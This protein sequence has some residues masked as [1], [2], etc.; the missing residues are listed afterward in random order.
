[1]LSEITSHA[2]PILVHFPIA[3]I[4]ISLLYELFLV[5]KKKHLA[6]T[7][8]LWLWILCAI[9]AALSVATGPDELA[10][11]NTTYI[12]THSRLADITMLLTFF[13]VAY[14]LWKWYK[15]S[16]IRRAQLV[17]YMLVTIATCVCV[18]TTGYY[19]GKMV[20]DQGIG[21]KKNGAYVTPPKNIHFHRQNG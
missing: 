19:G 3:L 10:R 21:V 7:D 14:K 17:F 2:H 5:W 15:Q 9:G 13:I 12:S 20:Y 11:G 16:D 4:T 1:M 6:P 18:L 8:G